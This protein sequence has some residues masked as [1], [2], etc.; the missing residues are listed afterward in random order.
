MKKTRLNIEFSYD[1]WL[2]GVSS[3]IKF[4]KLAWAINNKLGIQLVR[5]SD[6]LIVNRDSQSVAFGIY[7][8]GE[9]GCRIELFRNRSLDHDRSFLLPE[10]N[11]FD[12]L[13]KVDSSLQSFSKEEILKELKDVQWIEYIAA[14]EVNDLKSKDNFLT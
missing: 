13:I 1:F 10:F 7:K 4:F 6:H 11:H 3:S 9:D 12:Y 2:F 5:H 8:C 14:L